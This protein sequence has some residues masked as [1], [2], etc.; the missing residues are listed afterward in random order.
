MKEFVYTKL[1]FVHIF[2]SLDKRIDD[3]LNSITIQQMQ[4]LENNQAECIFIFYF[5]NFEF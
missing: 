4:N 1:F 2:S 5:F 3:C